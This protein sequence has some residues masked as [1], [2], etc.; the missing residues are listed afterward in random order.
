MAKNRAPRLRSDFNLGAEQAE[1]DPLLSTAFFETGDYRAIHAR[2]DPY[3]FI[4]GRTGAGK[5]AALQYLEEQEAGRV[6]RIAPEDL[7]LPYITNLGVI[8][9]LDDLN[10]KLDPFFIA[11]WK[12]VLLVEIIRH[13]Y[14]VNS[15]AAKRNIMDTLRAK[16]QRDPTK[17]AALA[18]LEEFADKFWCE[19]DERVREITDNLERQIGVA[20]E[21]P[22]PSPAANPL[23][24]ATAS[25]VHSQS[26]RQELAERFQR[27]VNDTQLPRLNQMI[28]VLH[29][30][31]VDEQHF[32]YVI[33]DDLDRD[34]VDERI[35]NDLIRCLFR[36]VVDLMRAR[37][38]KILVA[39]RTNIFQQLEF[40]RTTG[41]EE[42]FRALSL[43]MR[44]DEGD[45]GALL[46]ERI[47]AASR[48]RGDELRLRTRDL[49]PNPNNAK[50]DPV[51]FM[52]ERTLRRPRDLISFA[53]EA[54]RGASGSSRVTW[55]DIHA[56]EKTYSS[57]RLLALRDEWKPTFPG[58][59]QV[60][61]V[62]R[63][64][65][66]QMPRDELSRRLDDAML[67]PADSGFP[68]TVWMTAASENMLGSG[69][70]S[71]SWGEL[72]GE[73]VQIL[74]SIGF[75]GLIDERGR[76]VW[77]H[78]EAG[79]AD[80][81]ASLDLTVGAEVHPAFRPALDI[82]NEQVGRRRHPSSA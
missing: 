70:N 5:S 59:D 9:Y 30:D 62:F 14:K 52:I 43:H 61:S 66:R 63:R 64:S 29:E 74:F 37:N 32:T 78:D 36:T 19:T 2:S 69:A 31:I 65:P 20:G 73:L 26:S 81:L 71:G 53:N 21:V 41:Q 38:V 1:A 79:Y 12:H 47:A 75:L 46:E 22:F 44:W 4:I 13:R 25:R 68:G 24:T 18:Y 67:L 23:L 50:G 49:L 28:K 39:L 11:L 57:K 55:A 27:I 80:S 82:A 56:A 8:R 16:V 6:I 34:W 77:A 35:A 40:G 58:I 33:I 60:M 45:L 51:K 54:L 48:E 17:Q 7:S 72:Y 3:R 15:P 10:V 42:K 76:T